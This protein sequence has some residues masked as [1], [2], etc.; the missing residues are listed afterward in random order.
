MEP[1]SIVVYYAIL[2][3]VKQKENLK[4]GC[5]IRG[6]FHDNYL[7]TEVKSKLIGKCE[8]VW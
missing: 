4:K 8:V 6:C 2:F 7:T 3:T 5:P 1:F